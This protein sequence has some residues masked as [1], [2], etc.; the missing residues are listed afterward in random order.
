MK[1]GI[2]DFD[3]MGVGNFS[4]GPAIPYFSLK[5]DGE[6]ADVRFMYES[7]NDVE[8]YVVHQVTFPNGKKRYVMCIRDYEDA[9]D[10]CPLCSSPVEADRKTFRKI[11]IPVYRCASKDIALWDRSADF[12]KNQLYPLMAEKGTPFCGYVFN[13]ERHGIKGT[14]EISYDILE[15][16]FDE[17]ILEDFGEVPNPIGTIVLEKNYQELADFVKV[18]N[19]RMPNSESPAAANATSNNSFRKTD[20]GYD[21][22]NNNG[23]SGVIRRRGTRPDIG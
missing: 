2:G 22:N 20:N 3:K 14:M 6:N 21:N 19:F 4:N 7:M 18:R 10:A 16:S 8:G 17:S 5:E 11:W 1:F 15:Q 12:F 9:A 23:G 13:I